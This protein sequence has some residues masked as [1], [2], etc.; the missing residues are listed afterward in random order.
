MRSPISSRCRGSHRRSS[1]LRSWLRQ[2]VYLSEKLALIGLAFNLQGRILEGSRYRWLRPQSL[3]CYES[4]QYSVS[5]NLRRL[6]LGCISIEILHV[7]SY[8]SYFF[9]PP[10]PVNPERP[11][12]PFHSVKRTFLSSAKYH[13]RCATC[14]FLFFRTSLIFLGLR[15]RHTQRGACAL[16]RW[17]PL[18]FFFADVFALLRLASNRFFENS[19]ARN[20]RQIVRKDASALEVHGVADRRRPRGVVPLLLG[21]RRGGAPR[22]LHGCR[23]RRRKK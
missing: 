7:G 19:A 9:R 4:L 15:V 3:P 8:D 11:R 5:S 1:C 2:A 10:P 12:Y 18:P 23:L 17:F 20:S 16:D 13:V 14:F 21:R 22:W 6:V